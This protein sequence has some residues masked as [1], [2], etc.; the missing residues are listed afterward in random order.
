MAMFSTYIA[1]AMIQAGWP[2]WVAFVLTVVLSFVLGV[3][4][5]RIIIRPVARAPVLT[6]VVVFIGLLLIFNSVAGWIFTYTIKAFP[7]PSRARRPSASPVSAARARRDRRDAWSCCCC[8]SPSSAS[9]RSAS[10][11]ARPRRT[12]LEPPGRH[13]RRLDAGARLGPGR[14]DRRG[15]RDDGGADRLPRP[16]HDGR[17]PALRLRRRPDGRHRQPGR[18]GGRRLHRRR[19]RE[20]GRRLP[21]R[22]PS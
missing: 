21:D 10:P 1:W 18:R 12:R 19:A 14:R 9:R 8:C 17:H 4:I 7:S 3:A 22:Q 6:A 15:G 11:C 13:P 20:P 5:E 16:E 2:Y